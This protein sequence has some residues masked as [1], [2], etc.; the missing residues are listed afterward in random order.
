MNS[1]AAGGINHI[2]KTTFSENLDAAMLDFKHVQ[3]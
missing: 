1:H 3:G 2:N